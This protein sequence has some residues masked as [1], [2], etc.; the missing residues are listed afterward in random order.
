MDHPF[1]IMFDQ[2]WEPCRHVWVK[3]KREPWHGTENP[4]GSRLEAF[5]IPLRNTFERGKRN[6]RVSL[7]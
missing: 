7:Q 1:W 3:Y 4:F 2:I 5:W 6:L